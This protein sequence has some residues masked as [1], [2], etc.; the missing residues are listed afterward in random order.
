MCPHSKT[1]NL[2]GKPPYLSLNSTQKYSVQSKIS[3]FVV[4]QYRCKA[5][6]FQNYLTYYE[7]SKYCCCRTKRRKKIS[8]YNNYNYYY[9][10][11]L[12]VPCISESC[13]EIKLKLN[14]YFHASLWC[15]KRFYEGLKAFIKP[16]EA[17]QRCV[18]IKI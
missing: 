9:I 15:P 18:K 5:T 7:K 2:I 10:L 3:F 6:F 16:F 14:F 4:A 12:P 8:D 17:P 11:T 1:W 13:I